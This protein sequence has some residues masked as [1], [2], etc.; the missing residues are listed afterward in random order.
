MKSLFLLTIFIAFGAFAKPRAVFVCLGS[1]EKLYHDQKISGPF[2]TLNQVVISEFLQ[3]EPNVILSRGELDE[4]CKNEKHPSM[5]I[6]EA[7]LVKKHR[8]FSLQKTDDEHKMIMGKK[9][10][11]S[12]MRKAPDIFWE[13]IA[14]IQSLSPKAY[15]LDKYIPEIKELKTQNLYLEEELTQK[16][17]FSNKKKLKSVFSKIKNIN[18]IFKKCSEEKKA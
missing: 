16:V 5:K 15:C 3:M 12:L 10:I 17:I 8:F 2:Y 9:S 14:G 6:L 7:L 11:D 1:E 18:F 13:F 4:V